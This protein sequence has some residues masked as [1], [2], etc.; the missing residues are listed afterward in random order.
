MEFDLLSKVYSK[1]TNFLKKS[2]LFLRKL[3][4]LHGVGWEI[5]YDSGHYL[6][7]LAANHEQDVNTHTDAHITHIQHHVLF[8]LG[9]TCAQ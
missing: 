7:C 5:M 9:F 8:L 3:H 2:T 1:K 4:Q 6:T